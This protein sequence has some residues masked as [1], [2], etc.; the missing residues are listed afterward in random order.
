MKALKVI[1]MAVVMVLGASS[2]MTANAQFHFGVKA[3]VNI[4]SLHLN[5]SALDSDNQAGFTG[6][7]MAEFTVPIIGVGADLSAMYVRRTA[8][9]AKENNIPTD[10][11]DYIE[12]PLNI[13]WKIGVP[14]ISKFVTPFITTGP[15]VSFLTSRK[16]KETY[17]NK[18]CDWAWNAGV[19]L[20]IMSKVQIH[21]SYGIGLTKAVKMLNV[22]DTESAGINGKNRY[23]TVTA[24]YIF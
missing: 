20:E 13:K 14:V 22:V 10:K 19:G 6:G 23:W 7:L 4:N 5:K 9:F 15:S 8:K 12:I 16:F 1:F 17:E 11:R 3:G 18:T 21:A 24:A 2:A